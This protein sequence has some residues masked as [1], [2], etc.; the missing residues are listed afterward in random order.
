MK[1]AYLEFDDCASPFP[2]LCC[3]MF[4]GCDCDCW[5]CCCNGLSRSLFML[6]LLFVIKLLLLIV[7]LNVSPLLFAD[8]KKSMAD[9]VAVDTDK[10]VACSSLSPEN[11]SKFLISAPL[12]FVLSLMEINITIETEKCRSLPFSC[13]LLPAAVFETLLLISQNFLLSAKF[14]RS[15]N[16]LSITFELLLVVPLT[17]LLLVPLMPDG[18]D[19][20]LPLLNFCACELAAAAAAIAETAFNEAAIEADFNCCDK[21]A[22]WWND[23][24]DVRFLTRA[25]V[26]SLDGASPK[27]NQKEK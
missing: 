19:F 9:A 27:T 21:F 4:C 20:R 16:I 7:V 24:D 26:S 25:D 15:L 3:V 2:P 23:A 13:C 1:I 14:K 5:C 17:M 22:G 12:P 6:V 10:F 18:I 8:L 11:R